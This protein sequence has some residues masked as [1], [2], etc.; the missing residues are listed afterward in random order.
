MVDNPYRDTTLPLSNYRGLYDPRSGDTYDEK[1]T[2]ATDLWN[3]VDD[4]LDDGNHPQI[5]EVEINTL[6][7]TQDWLS[8]EAGDGPLWDELE[9]HPVVIDTGG[10]RYIL[11]GHHRIAKAKSR[12]IPSIE[13]YYIKD[14]E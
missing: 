1:F 11:D 13:V 6:L 14:N 8:T 2:S 10:M 9:D 12:G 3:K 7:A 5:K 4:M